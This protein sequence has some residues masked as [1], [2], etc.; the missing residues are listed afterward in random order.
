MKTTFISTKA[1]T[2]A[3]RLSMLKM[4]SKLIDAQKELASGRLADVGQSLGYKAGTTVSLRQEH[5]RLTTMRDT[6]GEVSARLDITQA[7]LTNL[8]AGAQD[9]ISQ[10]IGSRHSDSGP[11]VIQEQAK[12][13]LK[14]VIGVLNN[15]FNGS[16]LFSGIN[17]DVKPIA[18]YYQTPAGSAQTSVA[19]AFLSAFGVAQSAPATVSITPTDMQTFLDGAFANLFDAPAWSADW[20]SASDQ[21]V[22]SRVSTYEL[23]E[24]GTNANEEA[25]R[26]LVGA[27]TMV[28]DLGVESLNQGT[29][30]TV[31]DTAVKMA[32]EAIQG[33]AK[34][35]SGLGTVEERVKKANERM[36]IQIDILSAH[37]GTLE[38]VDPYEASTRVST[39]M[40]Q[41]ETAYALTARLQKLSL[42]NYL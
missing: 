42:V 21:N 37:I 1:I 12:N 32:G 10:L 35:Q 38:G 28:A 11:S 30:Q 20:S 13:D 39:L 6:N 29:F 33:L 24:S 22:R 34:Q 40:T 18:D 5:T 2:D 17:A 41:I 8:V 3:T 14:S 31:V 25:F 7:S 26:K 9:F 23:L 4:Q 36:S 27:Y 16:Y 19:N 15:S